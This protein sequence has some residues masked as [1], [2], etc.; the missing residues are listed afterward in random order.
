M[1][2]AEAAGLPPITGLYATIVPLLAYALFGPSRI[3]VL[4][5]DSSLA[6]LIAAA[7]VP[8]AAGDPDERGRAGRRCSPSSP[9]CCASPPAWPGFG[10]LTDLLSKPVRYGYLNGIALDRP[11]QPAAQAVRLLG[12]RRRAAR[13]RSRASWRA[14][15]RRTNRAA[16][17]LGVGAS[18]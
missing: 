13:R 14:C 11:R 17:A 7:I 5:P 18:P 12:R 8:L 16:L 2:Y 1:G 10:F 15:R 6:P 4:G 9:G 3:L